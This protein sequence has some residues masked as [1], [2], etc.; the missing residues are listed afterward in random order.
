MDSPI[1]DG[2]ARALGSTERD[3]TKSAGWCRIAFTL[4]RGETDGRSDH[5][6][7]PAPPVIRAMAWRCAGQ[8]PAIRYYWIPVRRKRAEAA[9]AKIVTRKPSAV[10]A[11]FPA[12]PTR[13]WLLSVPTWS[14]ISVPFGGQADTLKSVKDSFREGQIV[15]DLTVPLASADG[16]PATCM[17]NV[18]N[19]SAAEQ[20]ASLVP[21]G[22]RVV[23][24]FHNVAADNLNDLE[25]SID[26]D[27]IVCGDNTAKPVIKELIAHLPG[28]KYVDGG[29]IGTR[30][31]LRPSRPY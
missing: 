5:R 9:A 2:R 3:F 30:E 15:G 22:V 20:A 27:V 24:A 4:A 11:T 16:M 10:P 18:P 23:S 12:K 26:C 31:P 14:A 17:L 7:H 1:A 28:C 8:K 6:W 13:M 19:G 21:K 29:P 25:G